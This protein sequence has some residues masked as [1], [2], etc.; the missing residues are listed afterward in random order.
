MK[1]LDDIRARMTKQEKDAGDSIMWQ[2]SGHHPLCIY[3]V[4]SYTKGHEDQ[5]DELTEEN[6]IKE[7]AGY[8]P[9]AVGKA[10][11][12]RGISASRSI[13]KYEQ[14]LW[15]LEDPLADEIGDFDDYGMTHLLTIA[16][17]YKLSTKDDP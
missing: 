17:K 12:E 15:V 9:F 11:D 7:M 16:E 10:E 3:L 6:V 13:W 2:A 14:W 4:E 8:M 5:V 1:T